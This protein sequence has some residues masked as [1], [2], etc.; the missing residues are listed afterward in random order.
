MRSL[1]PTLPKLL[2]NIS[3]ML[4]WAFF[5][6]CSMIWYIE[7]GHFSWIVPWFDIKREHF[8]WIVPWFIYIETV[9][10]SWIVP[11]FDILRWPF[12]WI[13]PWFD[14]LRHVTN[15]E[16]AISSDHHTLC[17]CISLT[18]ALTVRGEVSFNAIANK[19]G[20]C[21]SIFSAMFLAITWTTGWNRCKQSDVNNHSPCQAVGLL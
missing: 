2:L 16:S 1:F 12:S 19:I 4:I 18:N 5:L 11:W 8:S 7:T 20:L 10:L 9:H 21:V 17:C 14:I 3:K 13:V 15:N 6:N